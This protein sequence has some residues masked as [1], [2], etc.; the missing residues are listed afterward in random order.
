MY[1][2]QTF[3]YFWTHVIPLVSL[4]CE[5]VMLHLMEPF[6]SLFLL[7][8]GANTILTGIFKTVIGI[9][10]E[11]NTG[12]F[13]N[14]IHYYSIQLKN[15]RTG[16][17]GGRHTW[18]VAEE[19]TGNRSQFPLY[20]FKLSFSVTVGSCVNTVTSMNHQV[21][22]SLMMLMIKESKWYDWTL[23]QNQ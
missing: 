13:S 7:W 3:Q 19:G 4:C 20:S 9:P 2:W 15:A 17:K 1:E 16:F 21:H 12:I 10:P 11:N 5:P 18:W 23:F 6:D 8:G 22:I 14:I